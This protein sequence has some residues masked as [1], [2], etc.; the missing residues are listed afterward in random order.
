M[1]QFTI[2]HHVLSEFFE[3]LLQT[4]SS[5]QQP[6]HLLVTNTPLC[7]VDFLELLSFQ[8]FVSYSQF[9]RDTCSLRDIMKPKRCLRIDRIMPAYAQTRYLEEPKT[10]AHNEATR[11]PKSMQQQ[12]AELHVIW[13]IARRPR[14]GNDS[15]WRP[16]D[17]VSK[18]RSG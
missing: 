2:K 17:A 8:F 10:Q 4:C 11:H 12:Q 13:M 6:F 5:R 9:Y 15:L 16:Q 1:F 14:V 7:D 18:W 3:D